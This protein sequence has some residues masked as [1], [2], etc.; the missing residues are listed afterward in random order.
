[1]A[2]HPPF[3]TVPDTHAVSLS[4]I[5]TP[6]VAAQPPFRTVPDPDAQTSRLVAAPLVAAN[7]LGALGTMPDAHAC[8]FRPIG[9]VH[10]GARPLHA[11][12]LY[13]WRG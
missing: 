9:A 5:G 11:T 2:A 7:R 12:G 10:D 4:L 8:L 6:I 3:R 13:L 1:M